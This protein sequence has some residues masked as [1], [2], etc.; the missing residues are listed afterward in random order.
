MV[1]KNQIAALGNKYRLSISDLQAYV[2]A[3]VLFVMEKFE[4]LNDYGR[5]I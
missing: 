2:E 3:R 5:D 4:I 1:R